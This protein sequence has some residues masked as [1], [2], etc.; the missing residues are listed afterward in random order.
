MLW[1]RVS[2]MSVVMTVPRG[3]FTLA[4]TVGSS[5]GAVEA[6]AWRLL[7]STI[8][9]PKATTASR[10]P[11]RRTRRLGSGPRGGGRRTER[12]GPAATVLGRAPEARG[13]VHQP[14]LSPPPGRPRAP[15]GVANGRRR[16]ARGVQPNDADLREIRV[17]LDED[18]VP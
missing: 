7:N 14:I 10:I 18:R 8:T 12:A 6:G 5:V 11:M 13:A 3:M 4:Y 17:V 9:P 2:T 1:L 15:L 16:G